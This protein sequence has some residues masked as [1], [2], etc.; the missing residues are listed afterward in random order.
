MRREGGGGGE[1]RK[2]GG[3]KE[4]RVPE[5]DDIGLSFLAVISPPRSLG[6]NAKYLV[7]I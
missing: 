4:K 7:G 3:G 6:K 1:R 2:R 5:K